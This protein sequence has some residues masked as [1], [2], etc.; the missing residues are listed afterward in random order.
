MRLII[1]L[2]TV[3]IVFPASAALGSELDD[4]LDR[5]REASYSAEQIITCSTPD[6]VEDAVVR[7][8]QVGGEIQVGAPVDDDLSVSSGYGGWTLLQGGDVVSRTAVEGTSDE[9]VA[10][11]TIDGGVRTE[12]LGRDAT[13][14]KMAGEG[15]IRAELVIDN[16]IGALLRVITYGADGEVYCERRFIT[17][18]TTPPTMRISNPAETDTLE[19]LAT[20]TNLPESLAGFTR[21]DQYS[22]EDGFVF[23]YYSDGFF[24]FAVFETPSIVRMEAPFR[25]TFDNRSYDRSFTPGQVIYSWESRAG[26]MALIGDLPPD[27][28]QKVLEGLPEPRDPGIFRRLWRNLFG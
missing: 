2:T 24:S 15:M 27:M 14:Y 3:L 25:M 26:A 10:R 18:D 21:L 16:E 5:S 13:V 19:S 17:F 1:A 11:Y 12:F 4:L 8:S 28:H 6:G 9:A 23:G 20:D 7:L 22:D